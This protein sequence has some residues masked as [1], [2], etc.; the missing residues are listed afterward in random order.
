M[1][2]PATKAPNFTHENAAE[3][4]KLAHAAIKARKEREKAILASQRPITDDARKDQTLRQIDRLDKLIFC[5]LDDNDEKRFLKLT[6]AKEKL[7][8]L[9][10][11]TAGALKPRQ[12]GSGKRSV[13]VATDAPAPEKSG[14]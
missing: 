14:V 5:A 12:P 3:M 13:P 8:K 10:Q 9:V 1:S 6:S 2:N 11:P 4:S 7:W